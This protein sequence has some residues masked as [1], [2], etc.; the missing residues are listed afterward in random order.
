MQPPHYFSG[1]ACAKARHGE[2]YRLLP[3]AIQ[4]IYHQRQYQYQAE[5]A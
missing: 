2:A 1:K 4:G 5:V 3:I